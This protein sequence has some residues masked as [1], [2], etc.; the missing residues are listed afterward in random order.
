[1][2]SSLVI[3]TE[4]MR[5]RFV[6]HFKVCP[7]PEKGLKVTW[8]ENKETKS[9]VQRNYFHGIVNRTLAQAM[10]YGENEMKEYLVRQ[11]MTPEEVEVEGFVMTV[12]KSTEL[13]TMEEY[14]TLI[15]RSLQFASEGDIFIPPS[16]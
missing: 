16:A 13:Y 3:R 11:F 1:M 5:D 10:G 6:A 2:N 14:S 12:W 15:D 7:I 8:G 4:R 9:A